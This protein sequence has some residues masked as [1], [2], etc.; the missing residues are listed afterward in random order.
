MCAGNFGNSLAYKH[1][2]I[3]IKIL[4]KRS[5]CPHILAIKAVMAMR[6]PPDTIESHFIVKSSLSVCV[7][8][9][10]REKCRFTCFRFFSW[11][12]SLKPECNIRVISNFS[13]NAEIF[14]SQDAPPVSI[15]LAANFATGTTVVVDTGGKFATGVKDTGSKFVAGVS[16]TAPNCHQYQ[17]HRWQNRHRCQQLRWQIMGTLSDWWHLKLNLKEKIYL[18]VYS[19]SERYQKEI[20]QTFMIEE[21]FRLPLLSTTLAVLEKIWNHPNGMLRAWRK[22]IHEKN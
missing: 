20:I 18:Y 14:A 21:S 4:T 22:L 7:S 13:E 8:A 11:I 15:T 2:K 17:W 10:E 12:T 19:T 3:K 6:L 16:D 5:A 1:L 9:G